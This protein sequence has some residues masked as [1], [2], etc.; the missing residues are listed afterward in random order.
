MKILL[1]GANG[2]FG[3]ELMRHLNDFDVETIS[4]RYGAEANQ[5]SKLASCDV[6]I[7]CG[8]LINGDFNDLFKSNVLLTKN[9]MD[10]LFSA[11]PKVHFIYFSSMSILQKKRHVSAYDYLNF[12]SMSDY[13]LSKYLAESICSRFR[14]RL[15]YTIVRFSTLFQKDPAKDGLSKLVYDG[16]VNNKITIFNDG[17]ATRD[18]MPLDIASQYVVRLVGQEK[19]FGETFN[20]VSGKETSFKEIAN[21]LCNKIDH[22]VVENKNDTNVV[23]QVASN[24][25]PQ[26]IF[27]IGQID[28]D[29]HESIISYLKELQS[30][31]KFRKDKLTSQV[32][33]R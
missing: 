22:L 9:I 10:Y 3:S 14:N 11:N 6:F 27:K 24:F 13:A 32:R 29:I 30:S 15:R 4:L 16:V 21:F 7:H 2:S 8:A 26:D 1:T 5:M 31:V 18:F 33:K 23:D 28:F 25:S 17:F 19:F 20:I 12:N